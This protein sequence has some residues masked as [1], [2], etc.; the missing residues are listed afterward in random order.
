M[1]FEW[2]LILIKVKRINFL[3]CNVDVDL[4][5]LKTLFPKI[6]SLYVS[7]MKKAYGLQLKQFN[8]DVRIAG[9]TFELK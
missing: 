1:I 9:Y 5:D 8:P 7:G 3:R 4:I 2:N 6:E